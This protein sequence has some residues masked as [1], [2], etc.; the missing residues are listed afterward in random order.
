M[1]REETDYRP[2]G[3]GV[4]V[5][6]FCIVIIVINKRQAGDVAAG[7]V[8]AIAVLWTAGYYARKGLRR[9]GRH[10]R[11]QVDYEAEERAVWEPYTR[12]DPAANVYRIGVRLIDPQHRDRGPLKVIEKGTCALIGDGAEK[13]R[14]ET[15]ASQTAAAANIKV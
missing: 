4:A 12:A 15:L 14:L 1:S 6:L 5:V 3:I 9:T 11:T 10:V 13:E 8:L 7:V 2:L